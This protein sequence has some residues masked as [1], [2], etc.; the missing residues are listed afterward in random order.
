MAS[1]VKEILILKGKG[2]SAME[3]PMA[4]CFKSPG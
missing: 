4:H 1:P 3:C 2:Q